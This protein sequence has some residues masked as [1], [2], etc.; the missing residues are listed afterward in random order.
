M[1]S[2]SIVVIPSYISFGL[3][4]H[5]PL[6]V[7]FSNITCEKYTVLVVSLTHKEILACLNDFPLGNSIVTNLFS[8]ELYFVWLLI[9]I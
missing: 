8:Q 9:Y 1:P 3:G 6:T 7:P 2:L 5:S 4:D